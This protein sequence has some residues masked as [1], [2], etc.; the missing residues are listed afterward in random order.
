M[1]YSIWRTKVFETLDGLVE[2]HGPEIRSMVKEWAER[3]KCYQCDQM[4]VYLGEFCDDC[5]E[6]NKNEGP[7]QIY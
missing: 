6:A 1:S 7:E 4:K 3:E 2:K 5:T